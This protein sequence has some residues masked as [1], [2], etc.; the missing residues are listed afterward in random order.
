MSEPCS[1]EGLVINEYIRAVERVNY[2]GGG[3]R[4]WWEGCSIGHALG[5]KVRIR[6]VGSRGGKYKWWN[7]GDLRCCSRWG[8][9]MLKI[10]RQGRMWRE[11]QRGS[12]HRSCGCCNRSGRRCSR[13][14]KQE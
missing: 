1:K 9:G 5:N 6:V 13:R 11:G 3:K 10:C 8:W 4:R 2:M 14:I 7:G 12:K